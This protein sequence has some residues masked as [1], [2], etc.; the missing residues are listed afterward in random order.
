[1]TVNIFRHKEHSHACKYTHT[2]THTCTLTDAYIHTH[3]QTQTSNLIHMLSNSGSIKPVNK[4][5]SRP[6]SLVANW[7]K[8]FKH[9]VQP[10]EDYWQN[11][12]FILNV[13]EIITKQIMT[14]VV[15]IKTKENPI[16]L[17]TAEK[18]RLPN[19]TEHIPWWINWIQCATCKIIINRKLVSWWYIV[20]G[21][22]KS[23]S[24]HT[25]V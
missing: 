16:Y 5:Y 11:G 6:V 12:L 17:W 24:H 1:M 22:L 10:S 8:L 23:L 9:I 25:T 18:T 19:V 2:H 4:T 20:V 14:P 15:I 13:N 21:I 3:K 7:L